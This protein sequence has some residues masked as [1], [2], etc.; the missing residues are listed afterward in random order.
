MKILVVDDSMLDRKLLIR[1][2]M[3]GGVAQEV[4]QVE[5]GEQALEVLAIHHK[6]IC[7]ILLDW[8][9][10]KMSGIELMA[11]MAKVPL[12]ASIPVIMVTASGSDENKKLAR[13]VNPNLAGYIV[14]PYK[15]EELL[16][17]VKPHLK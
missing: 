9:M 13:E 14:K 6:E 16:A 11:G 5:D 3:K 2:L 1:G 8:Q 15:P 17:A 12:L 4:L 10:P 7:L